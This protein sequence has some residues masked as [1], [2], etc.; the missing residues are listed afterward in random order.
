M[1]CT[2][3][4]GSLISNSTIS[5]CKFSCVESVRLSLR[6][7]SWSPLGPHTP[8]IMTVALTPATTEQPEVLPLFTPIP[9]W[10]TYRR[11]RKKWRVPL[12]LVHSGPAKAW[13]FRAGF[14]PRYYIA[15][16]QLKYCT[17]TK[18][19]PGEP[20]QTFSWANCNWLHC[21]VGSN[22]AITSC[23]FT[24]GGLG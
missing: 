22:L 16:V 4:R 15:F 13:R 12:C 24:S 6:A 9:S 20:E 21:V 17:A 23:T 7:C 2:R 10:L 18:K 3:P 1:R 11:S 19:I 5:I 14:P 8:S